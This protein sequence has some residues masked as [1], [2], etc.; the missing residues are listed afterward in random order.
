MPRLIEARK[1]GHTLTE[2][3]GGAL[4]VVLHPDLKAAAPAVPQGWVAGVSQ[5]DLVPHLLRG[6]VFTVSLRQGTRRL[7]TLPVEWALLWAAAADPPLHVWMLEYDDLSVDEERQIVRAALLRHTGVISK[8][9]AVELSARCG[10]FGLSKRQFATLLSLSEASV[11]YYA[12]RARSGDADRSPTASTPGPPG[13]RRGLEGRPH[14][15]PGESPRGSPRVAPLWG[16]GRA[17][18]RR[19]RIATAPEWRRPES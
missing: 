5:H 11:Q 8:R 17:R 6:T 18:W 19:R 12:P 9:A 10:F 4:R 1:A 16:R 2:A 7:L 13:A 14:A 15:H 3:H